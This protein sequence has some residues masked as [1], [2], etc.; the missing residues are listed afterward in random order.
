MITEQQKQEI[1][2]RIPV[3]WGQSLRF[4]Q[5]WEPLVYQLH[6]VVKALDPDYVLYQ[7]KEK[8]GGLRYYI[9]ITTKDESRINQIRNIIRT[10]ERR[11]YHIC[12]TCGNSGKLVENNHWYYT[13]CENHMK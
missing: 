7:C 1:L 10:V 8:F 13:S 3:E 2:D 11:S 12:E 5:G 4:N 9:G 6:T